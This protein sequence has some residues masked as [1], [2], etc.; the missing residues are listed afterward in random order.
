VGSR[1]M[2]FSPLAWEIPYATGDPKNT[3]KK[4][5]EKKRKEKEKEKKRKNRVGDSGEGAEWVRGRAEHGESG[6]R[7]L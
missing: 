2:W 6:M 3:K 5:K 7:R 4:E 1:K